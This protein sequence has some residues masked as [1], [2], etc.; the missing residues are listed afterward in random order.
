MGKVDMR[1]IPKDNLVALL[2]RVLELV[3]AKRVV[4]IGTNSPHVW[5]AQRNDFKFVLS[6]SK[7]GHFCLAVYPS[8]G[9]AVFIRSSGDVELGG[10]FISLWTAVRM[11][12]ALVLASLALE[13]LDKEFK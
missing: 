7:E 2:S 3:K 13:A 1:P 11:H 6:K 10:P 8:A 12:E 4:F 5:K 9:Q